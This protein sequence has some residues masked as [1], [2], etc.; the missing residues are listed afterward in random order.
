[1]LGLFKKKTLFLIFLNRIF[2]EKLSIKITAKNK[3]FIIPTL[4]NEKLL[5][6]KCAVYDYNFVVSD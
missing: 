6:N 3:K 1:M 5:K 2:Y 4:F